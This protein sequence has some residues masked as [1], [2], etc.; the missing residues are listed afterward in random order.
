[1]TRS[2]VSRRARNSASVMIG[3]GGGR[4]RG[5][6]GGAASW[7]RGGSS[8]ATPVDLVAVRRAERRLR[9]S[10]TRTTV[11]GGSSAVTSS[12][13]PAPPPPRCADGDGGDGRVPPS[14]SVVALGVLV[15]RLAVRS[16]S[17]VGASSPDPAASALAGARRRPSPSPAARRRRPRPP[18]RRRRRRR[19]PSPSSASSSLVG[20]VELGRARRQ[21]RRPR[22]PAARRA[23]RRPRRSPAAQPTRLQA[24]AAGTAARRV[25]RLAG[26]SGRGRVLG[27][28]GRRRRRSPRL[29]VRRGR[30]AAA[31]RRRRRPAGASSRWPWPGCARRGLRRLRAASSRSASAG[32][33]RSA[34]GSVGAGCGPA[35]RRRAAGGPAGRLAAPAAARSR[36]AGALGVARPAAPLSGLVGRRSGRSG[37]LAVEHPVLLTAPGLRRRRATGAP[38]GGAGRCGPPVGGPKLVRALGAGGQDRG[39]V[40]VGRRHVPLP[41][42]AAPAPAG[43]PRWDRRREV[44]HRR[45]AVEDVVGSDSRC[46]CAVRPVA[47]S[48]TARHR[49]PA[50]LPTRS[51]RRATSRHGRPPR[52]SN[53]RMPFLVSRSTSHLVARPGRPPPRRRPA[54]RST[55]ASRISP[56]RGLQPVG[57]RA[58]RLAPASTT[59]RTSSPG[60]SASSRAAR[61]PLGVAALGR[62]RSRGTRPRWPPRSGAAFA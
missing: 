46:A 24:P 45:S 15:G 39:R 17:S 16:A 20:E 42:R 59:S 7:P 53:V 26:S 44:G 13:L 47:V 34:A 54:P 11:F 29:R 5:P 28:C 14:P 23:A 8:R 31:P 4:P 21:R 51:G 40:P 10:R 12:V 61:T 41:R 33:S 57:E 50:P 36:A 52:A 49:P 6:R 3:A 1:M 43:S 19:A 56:H 62:P 55:P 2:T 25:R 37:G 22:P 32:A 9:G 35:R 58:A 48:H 27:G 38:R 30:S 18:R 60:G